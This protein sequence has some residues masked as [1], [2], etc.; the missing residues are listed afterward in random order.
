M[1]S[2]RSK[3]VGWQGE[4]HRHY[5]AAKGISTGQRQYYA[6]HGLLD[7]LPAEMEVKMFKE[8][9]AAELRNRVQD[10]LMAAEQRGEISSR[11]ANDFIENVFAKELGFYM[12]GTYDYQRFEDEVM[13]QLHRDIQTHNK[14]L[15]LPFIS[16][17]GWGE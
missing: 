4:S 12:D 17:K 6:S 16:D 1:R 15:S 10:E 8:R 13:R 11:T 14:K 3:P 9:R 7:N 2:F 5:L